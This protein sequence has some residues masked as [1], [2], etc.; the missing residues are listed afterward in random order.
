MRDLG[1]MSYFL[2]LES[3][4]NKWCYLYLTKEVCHRH[5]NTIQDEIF[6][7]NLYSY[8]RASRNEKVGNGELEHFTYFK[9]IVG[10]LRYLTFTRPNIDYGL[11]IINWFIEEPYQS[12]LQI[13][14][15]NLRYVSG[16]RDYGI[17]YSYSS[18]FSLVGYANS[19]WGGDVETRKS[20]IRNG[21]LF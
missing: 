3:L 2:G 4:T 7:T 16:T 8:C 10:S 1:L 9:G 17:F 5:S 20:T 18:N 13:I 12:H 21:F 19:D 11:G 15:Q 6:I 14:K